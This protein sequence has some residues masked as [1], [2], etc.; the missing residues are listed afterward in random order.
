[1]LRYSKNKIV[2]LIV[3]FT[4]TSCYIVFAEKEKDSVTIITRGNVR[5][6]FKHYGLRRM[7]FDHDK[8]ITLDSIYE[9]NLS[10]SIAKSKL[11][12]FDEQTKPELFN[13][14]FSS[15][16]ITEE[17]ILLL[18]RGGMIYFGP[19]SWDILNS[20]PLAMKRFFQEINATILNAGNYKS[21]IPEKVFSGI[22]N[23][24]E[25][26]PFL[27]YPNDLVK[28]NWM[29]AH[30]N[31]YW[32]VQQSSMKT[33]LV[34]KDDIQRKI[35]IVE[36][37]I[38]NNGS[39]IWNLSYTT[40][41]LAVDDFMENILCNLYNLS[42]PSKGR[43]QLWQQNIWQIMTPDTMSENASED[44]T[45]ISI[46]VQK[47]RRKI[48][49]IIVTNPNSYSVTYRLEPSA[50]RD[51]L[52]G[53]SYPFSAMFQL[54]EAIPRLNS[55]QVRQF[56]L[57]CSLNEGNIFCIP[58]QETRILVL[59]TKGL[60]QPGRYFSVLTFVPVNN[61]NNSRNINIEVIVYDPIFEEQNLLET[62]FGETNDHFMRINDCYRLAPQYNITYLQA[63]LPL[64]AISKNSK[65]IIEVISEKEAFFEEELNDVLKYGKIIYPKDI[66]LEFDKRLR[67]LDYKDQSFSS[68]WTELFSSWLKKWF[69]YLEKSGIT[70][71]DFKIIVGGGIAGFN[72]ILQSVRL[73]KSIEPDVQIIC[74]PPEESS[75][76]ELLMLNEYIDNWLI[77]ENVLQRI[78]ILSFYQE[79]RKPIYFSSM[80][81]ELQPHIIRLVGIKAWLLG[82]KG[83]FIDNGTSWEESYYEDC[84]FYEGNF[85]PI[86]TIHAEAMREASED[87]A[88]IVTA[89][90]RLIQGK[91]HPEAMK[92]ITTENL[93]NLLKCGGT[94]IVQDWRNY[95]EYY[96]SLPR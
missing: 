20:L 10:Q 16:M 54:K 72:R 49:P 92:L 64:K 27:K 29:E 11:I 3:F 79:S 63:N 70:Y 6:D 94:D 78:E 77:Y 41:R 32:D 47:S 43:C 33:L 53:Y 67:F 75:T 2:L 4:L 21:E 82:A 66:C 24:V 69:C 45:Y 50:V 35:C 19:T 40:T 46:G 76:A 86:S 57:I 68:Q 83:F 37:K 8:L 30:A 52:S 17:L 58:A 73:I 31:R 56:E 51:E 95:L 5:T 88:L 22:A 91:L 90:D 34:D 81:T 74:A 7:Y 96:L 1:M 42:P 71:N 23:S 36:E 9:H 87:Y 14:F 39:I 48:V 38:M 25:E 55:N 65:N 12:I 85:G 59:D 84:F 15:K 80:R 93:M 28:N 61:A 18:E 89:Q 60:I 26:N 13:S 44:L 62:F